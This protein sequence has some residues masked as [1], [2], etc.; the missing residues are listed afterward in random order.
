M[1]HGLLCAADV[2]AQVALGIVAAVMFGDR[3]MTEVL[4]RLG[5]AVPLALVLLAA[6]RSATGS[7]GWID[8]KKPR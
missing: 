7:R 6:W 2:V 1:R 5:F 8:D 4:A 3:S